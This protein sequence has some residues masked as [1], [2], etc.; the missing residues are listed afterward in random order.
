MQPVDPLANRET[1]PP[2][3]KAW[4]V[5]NSEELRQER[6]VRDHP[7]IIIY[8]HS[9]LFYW[10]PVWVFGFVM[11]GITWTQGEP[12]LLEGNRI[13]IYPNSNLGVTYVV[14]LTLVLL[15]TNVTVRGLA[16][17]IVILTIMLTTVLLA[18]YGLWDPI[19]AWFGN[20]KIYLNTGA[21]FW[22]STVVFVVWFLTVF[23]FDRLSYWSIKPGQ[24]T[25]Q[26]I[27]GAASK[28]YDT[29]NLVLEKY[30]DDLFRHWILGFGSGDLR[31]QPLGANREEIHVPNVLF[32]GS[33]MHA[34]KHL[35]ATQPEDFGHFYVH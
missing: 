22:L 8:S 3:A 35:I 5:E 27:F 13:Q 11:A 4:P 1:P 24:I 20:L 9:S 23:V 16:S 29:E 10:W 18:F 32:I 7:E 30:R 15:I 28:T 12:V 21:Y 2:T 33:R 6:Q 14:I 17:A 19:L 31:F 34:I 25:H 26:F